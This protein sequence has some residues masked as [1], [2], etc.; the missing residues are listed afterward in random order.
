MNITFFIGNGFDLNL[1]LNTK[2]EHFYPYF[3]E[4]ANK[5]NIIRGLLDGN[6][7]YWSDLEEKLG[8]ELNN[9]TQENMDK[10]NENKDELD[11]L[12]TE[13]LRYEQNKYL[14]EE[15][16]NRNQM[17]VSIKSF[18]ADMTENNMNSIQ[19]TLKAYKDEEYVYSF[20]IF[21][22]TNTFDTMLSFC[23][24]DTKII[25]N[26]QA[27]KGLK[28]NRIGDIIHIH[29]TTESGMI[30]AVNDASQINNE[31]LKKDEI[32]LDTFIKKRINANIGA[33][34]TEKTV[35]VIRNSRI[36]CIYGMSI[37][38]TDKIWWEELIKWLISNS[39]N[40]LVIFCKEK[41]EK[42]K[43]RIPAPTIR[44]TEK[45]RRKIFENGRGNRTETEYK[46][47]KDRIMVV[48][49]SRIFSFRNI[50]DDNDSI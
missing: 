31:F 24:K 50:D 39:N 18:Y 26:H 25:G 47:I 28:N 43:S 15:E 20:V 12:L 29:G 1:G 42:I 22:Y 23:M 7:K 16:K 30:L 33:R 32:F 9:I 35:D 41:E 5:D 48:F 19:T 6:E 36:I 38:I 45:V 46:Q 37:G 14:Y 49:N 40:K 11:I 3:L 2:Y 13:Y 8:E 17:L 4:K 27:S 44:M 10:Y 21:N 34:K